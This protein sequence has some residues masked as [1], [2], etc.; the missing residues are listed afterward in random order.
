MSGVFGEIW[1]A[2]QEEFSFSSASELTQSGVRL[3]IALLLGALVGYDRE[4]KDRAAGLRTHML[5]ALGAALFVVA[6]LQ[7]GMDNADVSRVL[8]GIVAGVGFLGAGAIIKLNEKEQVKG[9]TTAAGVWATAAIG[10]TAGMGHIATAAL[11][12]LFVVIILAI[13]PRLEN[14]IDHASKRSPPGA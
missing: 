3:L 13:L 9:L 11:S 5:V 7:S 6:G 4:V 8:Q 10:V 12:T 2:L 14:R 1:L